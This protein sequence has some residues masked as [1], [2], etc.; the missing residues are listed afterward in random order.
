M[1]NLHSLEFLAE[2]FRCRY[3][4]MAEF[5]VPQGPPSSENGAHGTERFLLKNEVGEDFA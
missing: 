4:N 1:K 5:P 3:Q 2:A